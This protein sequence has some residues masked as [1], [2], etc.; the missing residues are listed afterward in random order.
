MQLLDDLR[1]ERKYW[2]LKDEELE[3]NVWVTRFGSNC[4]R[5]EGTPCTE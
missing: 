2:E 4:K 5:L 1:E 3:H